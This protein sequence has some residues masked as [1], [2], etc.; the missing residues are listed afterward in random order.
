MLPYLAL[1]L[2]AQ[3]AFAQ[4]RAGQKA[5]EGV[6]S[7]V[8]VGADGNVEK[9]LV[10]PP[11]SDNLLDEVRHE[12]SDFAETLPDY[13]CEQVTNRFESKTRGEKWKR[14]DRLTADLLYLNGK[15]SYNNFKRNGKLLNTL[16]ESTGT[17][18][19]GEFATMMLDVFARTTN[20]KFGKVKDVTY[21]QIAAK[22]YDF[23]VA[24]KSSHWKVDYD[25][26][27]L[28][29]AFRG[30]AWLDPQSRRVLRVEIRAID[31][32]ETYPADRIEMAV[33]YGPVQIAGEE[34]LFAISADNLFCKRYSAHCSSNKIRYRDCKKFSAE[35]TVSTTE[36]KISF[37][38]EEKEP[39]KEEEPDKK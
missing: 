4:K 10:Q 16:P 35:S 22:R 18:S 2:V 20:A 7:E 38:G 1:L 11:G 33:D 14:R 8:I 9:V 6:W 39:K 29:P 37:E 30:S 24:Q 26:Q 21:R 31:I 12:A 5:E 15:E 32:P 3:A 23:S 28:Y 19:Y 13:I 36:S 17:W 34:Y 27:I 25:H